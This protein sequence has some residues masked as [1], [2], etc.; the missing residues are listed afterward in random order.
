MIILTDN[1]RPCIIVITYE[2]RSSGTGMERQNCLMILFFIILGG[3]VIILSSYAFFF[4][5]ISLQQ[6]N[7]SNIIDQNYF[8]PCLFLLCFP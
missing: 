8:V 7:Q 3:Y 5:D 2:A 4:Y 6:W 1:V